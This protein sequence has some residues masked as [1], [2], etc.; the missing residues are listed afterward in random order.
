MSV[1][2]LTE[3]VGFLL[4]LKR[5]SE[6]SR[7]LIVSY[8]SHLQYIVILFILAFLQT[9]QHESMLTMML[10]VELVLS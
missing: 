10:L 8:L 3:S 4:E 1:H 9:M 7:K 5:L 2:R 6:L